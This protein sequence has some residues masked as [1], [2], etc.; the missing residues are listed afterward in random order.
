MAAASGV[1]S[2]AAQVATDPWLEIAKTWVTYI[3]VLGTAIIVA[4]AGVRKAL[5][6][7]KTGEVSGTVQD[8]IMSATLI[9]THTMLL[10]SESNRS[11]TESVGDLIDKIE[12]M[13]KAL[14]YN[15]ETGREVCRD[16]K[17]LRHQIERLR[18]KMA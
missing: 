17:E 16:M 1:S 4:I 3:G 15:T 8:K 6:D 11:V 5:K 14:S 10:W 12:S 7:L 13:T 18:D 9:E 2:D